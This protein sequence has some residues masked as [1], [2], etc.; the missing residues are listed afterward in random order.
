MRGE[1]RNWQGSH[2]GDAGVHPDIVKG[3]WVYKGEARVHYALVK[4]VWG[5][6]GTGRGSKWLR[7]AGV[8]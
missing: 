7:R 1:G 4:G 6:Q 8:H 5:V 3:D 2:R